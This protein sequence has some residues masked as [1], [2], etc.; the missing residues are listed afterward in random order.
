MRVW[1]SGGLWIGRPSST[2]S[3]VD[4]TKGL[5]RELANAD[6]KTLIA[7]CNWCIADRRFR[8][9]PF[10]GIPK[11]NQAADPRRQR[12]AMTE[13]ELNRLL[14]VARRR[15]LLEVET[16]HKGK[17]KGETYGPKSANGSKNSGGNSAS[18]YKALV[19]TGLRRNELGTLTVSQ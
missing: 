6:R 4:A 16:V 8:S 2:G 18:I 7:F 14:E 9:N 13:A 1:D 12:R 15:P 10:K 5:R 11:A 19:L 3:I 17:R